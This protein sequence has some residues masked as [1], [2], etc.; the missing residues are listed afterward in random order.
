MDEAVDGPHCESPLLPTSFTPP[1]L[2]AV[3][4][5]YQGLT[6]AT[7]HPSRA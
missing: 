5:N 4:R 6:D 2:L 1:P 3:P 7:R